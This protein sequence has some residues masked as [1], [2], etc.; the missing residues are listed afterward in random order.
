MRSEDGV[1]LRYDW[2]LSSDGTWRE[3]RETYTGAPGLIEHRANVAPALEALFEQYAGNHAMTVYGQ[4]PRQLLDLAEA[5]HNDRGTSPGSP[6]SKGSNQPHALT[7][8]SAARSAA[9]LAQGA[10]G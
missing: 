10:A 6:S 2:F 4:A 7:Q 8:Y 3:V 5:H 9:A 1:M